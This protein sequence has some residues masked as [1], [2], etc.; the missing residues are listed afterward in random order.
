MEN[1]AGD[2]SEMFL[3]GVT[4]QLVPALMGFATCNVKLGYIRF[5]FDI[6]LSGGL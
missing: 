4:K 3:I 5:V 1:H 2:W 6:V